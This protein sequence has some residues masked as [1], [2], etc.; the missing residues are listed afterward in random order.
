MKK[1]DGTLDIVGSAL[2]LG[3]GIVSLVKQFAP[4]K[5]QRK[6]NVAIRRL[7]HRFK[8]VQV[9]T[10]VDINFSEY[11]ALERAEIANLISLTINRT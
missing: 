2:M 3:N 6:I 4:D 7:T 5:K 9:A 8:A 10:Y 11:P 1:P